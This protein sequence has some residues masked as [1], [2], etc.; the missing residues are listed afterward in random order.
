MSDHNYG[1]ILA[2]DEHTLR[3][4][5]Q[6][7]QDQ[8]VDLENMDEGP[9]ENRV[10]TLASPC[11]VSGPGTFSGGAQQTL[12]F[13]PSDRPGWWIDRADLADALPV[14]VAIDNVWTTGNI[15]SNIVL[16]AGSPHNYL[17]MVEHIIALRV[18][19]GLDNVIVRTESGD[20]PLLERGSLDLVEAIEKAG[21]V[22]GETLAG[23]VTVKE[24]VSIVSPQ[25][26]FLVIHPAPAGSRQLTLDCAVDFPNAIGKQRIRFDVNR[27]S[28]R[29]G[30]FARTNTSVGVM[31]YCMTIGKIFAD[32]RNLGYSRK[33]LLIAGKRDYSNEARLIHEGKSL[34]AAWHRSTLDLLA[35][36]ALIADGRFA[37]HIESYKAGH[38]LDCQMVTKLYQSDLLEPVT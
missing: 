37:G 27:D 28:C 15:V 21:I 2:G 30:S 3:D 4:A 13:L 5:C 35:A 10:T 25:G 8:S 26:S 1:R 16:R 24:T 17:R 14:R 33:N 34:E 12:T 22:P 11:S 7:F 38:S 31:L 20:P 18:G 9:R 29:H 32:V 23:Y 36:V 19:L 6:R